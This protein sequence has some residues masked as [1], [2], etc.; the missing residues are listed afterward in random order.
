[1]D[2]GLKDKVAL[3]TGGGR[4][5]GRGVCL[6]LADE[7]AKVIVNDF[8]E[9]RA[10]RVASEIEA[11]GGRALA[12]QADITQIAQVRTMVARA[13]EV[14]GPVATLVNNAGIPA[15]AE[16]EEVKGSSWE[17]FHSSDP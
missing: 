11:R 4:G 8:H 7:G 12:I 15:R 9:R 10:A 3:V 17:E 5:V 1:M 14:L 6:R 16:N 2:L 13:V